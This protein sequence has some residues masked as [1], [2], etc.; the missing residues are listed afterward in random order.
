MSPAPTP[1]IGHRSSPVKGSVPGSVF[2]ED[3]FAVVVAAVAGVVKVVAGVDVVVP[4]VPVDGAEDAAELDVGVP[5]VDDGVD[6]GAVAG[7]VLPDVD[8]VEEPEDGG[9]DPARG[10][11]Y[12]WSPADDPP[13]PCATAPAGPTSERRTA[14]IR[15]MSVC[16]ERTP[17]VLQGS[18]CWASV[19]RRGCRRGRQ[20]NRQ[21][22][23]LGPVTESSAMRGD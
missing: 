9:E 15:Q 22:A 23:A 19:L 3:W 11:T 16:R 4:A 6:D 13:P 21:R 2:A 10:S 14:A 17:R 1:R 20:S 5:D 12:C 18:R 7:E 8:G